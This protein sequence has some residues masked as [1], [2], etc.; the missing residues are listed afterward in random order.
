[1]VLL[2][3]S[4]HILIFVLIPSAG[5]DIIIGAPLMG[6]ID[7]VSSVKKLKFLLGKS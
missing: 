4:S 3:R 1:M 7:D 6:T 5:N 2:L